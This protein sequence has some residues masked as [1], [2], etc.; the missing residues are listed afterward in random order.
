MQFTVLTIFPEMFAAFWRYGIVRRAIE[1]G[2][3][4]AEAVNI[5]DF[6]LTRHQVTDDRP[7]GG[8][9]GMVMKPE[10]L[11]AAIRYAKSRCPGSPVLLLSPQGR[12]FDQKAA[13]GLSAEAG[14][15]L[16]C[17][18]Y[19][20]ID[21]RICLKYVDA[22]ISVGNFILTGGE[23]PAMLVIDAVTRL[24]PG[25]LGNEAA[26]DRESFSDARLEH[27]HYTR[28]RVFENL[29]VPEV[30]QSGNHAQ[31]AAWRQETALIR[32]FLKRR[33]LLLERGLS[34]EEIDILKKWRR[35]IEEMVHAESVCGA[36][37][38]SGGQ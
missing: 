17:G 2:K 36:D 20:G 10:P 22:E 8:G 38:L 9:P 33:E 28:P 6:T 35:E 12:V 29:A 30:L 21:E 26:G 18:R 27:G 16:V 23:V 31:I 37:A 24:L 7:Y 1:R 4:K 11:A 5:R 25:A 34:A 3:V 13:Q 19:Q 14:L 32:T 15:I